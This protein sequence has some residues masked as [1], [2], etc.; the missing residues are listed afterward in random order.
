MG[1]ASD[2]PVIESKALNPS[3]QGL[4]SS[5]SVDEV[6][7]PLNPEPVSVS[8]NLHSID[9][10]SPMH[11]NNEEQNLTKTPVNS[12]RQLHVQEDFGNQSR[13][14][15]RRSTD[16]G[17]DFSCPSNSRET[18]K[19]SNVSADKSGTSIR[20]TKEYI[21]S[22]GVRTFAT[23]VDKVNVISASVGAVN[24]KGLSEVDAGKYCPLSPRKSNLSLQSE[25]RLTISEE[26]VQDNLV[27]KVTED[28]GAC[29]K[30]LDIE[31]S[32]SEL[33]EVS[34]VKAVLPDEE[35]VLS[36]HQTK[37]LDSHPDVSHI[38]PKLQKL[39]ASASRKID[40]ADPATPVSSSRTKSNN[41]SLNITINAG[42]ETARVS[43]DRLSTDFPSVKSTLKNISASRS[44][45]FKH[46]QVGKSNNT[47][48]QTSPIS[49]NFTS[50][51]AKN[52]EAKPQN[53]PENISFSPEL[54]KLVANSG[55]PTVNSDDQTGCSVSNLPRKKMDARKTLGFRPKVSKKIVDDQK[56]SLTGN[57]S[58]VNAASHIPGQ[59]DG[60]DNANSSVSNSVDGSTD[61]HAEPLKDFVFDINDY[62]QPFNNDADEAALTNS[63]SENTYKQEMTG[64]K[65]KGKEHA[66]QTTALN[67]GISRQAKNQTVISAPKEVTG[68]AVD[69]VGEKASKKNTNVKGQTVATVGKKR[70]GDQVVKEPVQV[71]NKP[72]A[73]DDADATNDA[74]RLRNLTSKKR[75]G[76]LLLNKS[77]TLVEVEKEIESTLDKDGQH[78]GVKQPEKLLSTSNSINALMEIQNENG[79]TAVNSQCTNTGVNQTRKKRRGTLLLAN[80]EDLILGD[81]ENLPVCDAKP[82]KLSCKVDDNIVGDDQGVI[83]GKKIARK[84]RR[85]TLL[86]S[87]A[88]RPLEAEK[89][90]EP[91]FHSRI[92]KS[93]GE[94]SISDLTVRKNNAIGSDACHSTAVNKEPAWF[95]VSGHRLQRKEF[96]QLIKCLKGKHCRDS[97]QWSYQA[98][99]FIVPDPIRRT[100]K[101]FAAAA[102]GSWILKTDYLTASSE[103]GKFLPEEPYEWHKSDLTEDGAINLEAP[104][105]WRLLKEKTGHGAFYGM[106]ILVY[107]ECIAP[108]LD[109]LKRVVKA[110]DGTILATS[111]PYTRFLKSEVDF[112]IVSPGITR[113]DIWVQEFL[114]HEIP[115]VSAD[116]L[117][118]YVCK[119]GYPLDR[120][121]QY[122]THE[123]AAK[124]FLRLSDLSTESVADAATPENEVTDDLACQV[125]G[126]ADRAEV[127]LICGDESGST[128][129]GVGTHIDCCDPPLED[130]PDEDWFCPKCTKSK[131]EPPSSTKKKTGSKKK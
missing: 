42:S 92:D 106:R 33:P 97:H 35:G 110:G 45:P 131:T 77:D 47:D 122:N 103:A 36:L 46:L 120:H 119:P 79:T 74:K 82:R 43:E 18:P 26:K 20:K 3:V 101:F 70:S 114:R 59:M 112:A 31:I 39:M 71:E 10:H 66:K 62:A 16:H 17:T 83:K 9:K 24:S 65:L 48:L 34:S 51:S 84:K 124:S 37:Q 23:E 13:P 96:Q 30:G 28:V 69:D 2:N 75:R 72:V 128:G 41:G 88:D 98:T 40:A 44:L 11:Q 105:K 5:V 121:V 38:T 111:P 117:V 86:L 19:R 25:A 27:E 76:T 73:S 63:T 116:Y 113:A 115:C 1:R 68:D 109:T 64:A 14:S 67:K 54:K 85:G 99:H 130:V 123:W 12:A 15:S 57:F 104:R 56:G 127:M 91:V 90:N 61:L 93:K 89:E 80:P 6:R 108:P 100:E 125:C 107:G 4:S 55:N 87:K 129:C 8:R 126:C 52:T 21:E 102:S 95:I 29:N 94:T 50:S 118:E 7:L 78:N 53:L 58:G 49:G 22:N 32:A 60:K 81:K